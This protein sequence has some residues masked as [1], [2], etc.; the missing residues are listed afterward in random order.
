MD[1]KG[2]KTSK[3][4]KGRKRRIGQSEVLHRAMYPNAH[5]NGIKLN[6]KIKKYRDLT[7]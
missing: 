3:A 1:G 5:G 2:D 4:R 6:K 7:P